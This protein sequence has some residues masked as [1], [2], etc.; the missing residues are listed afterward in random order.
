MTKEQF[1]DAQNVRRNIRA[2]KY[3]LGRAE[4]NIKMGGQRSQYTAAGIA[5]S[6]ELAAFA[7][8]RDEDIAAECRINLAVLKAHFATL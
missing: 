4:L 5:E 7:K 1:K 6:P 2:E 3:C 8:K